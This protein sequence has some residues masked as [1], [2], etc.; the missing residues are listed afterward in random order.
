[1]ATNL[2]KKFLK[3]HAL[4]LFFEEIANFATRIADFETP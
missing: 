3:R 1:M 4:E 2:I